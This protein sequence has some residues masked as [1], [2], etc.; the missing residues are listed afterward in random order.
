[1]EW[2]AHLPLVGGG[3]VSVIT[4]FLIQIHIKIYN[5]NTYYPKTS[6]PQPGFLQ[7]RSLRRAVFSN[8]PVLEKMFP[9]QGELSPS[10]GI[11]LNGLLST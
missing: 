6:K 10:S 5:S 3:G 1:M 8:T 7:N 4:F 2:P 11:T 9:R